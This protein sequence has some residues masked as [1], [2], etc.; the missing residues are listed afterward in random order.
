MKVS[1]LLLGLDRLLLWCN[2]NVLDLNIS[3]C[4]VIEFFRVKSQYLFKYCLIEWVRT[5]QI[6]LTPLDT[7]CIYQFW[8]IAF[9]YDLPSIIKK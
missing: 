9:P 8:N 1:L 6:F 7:T 5:F 4:R 2:G 3:K